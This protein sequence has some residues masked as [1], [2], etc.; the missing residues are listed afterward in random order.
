MYKNGH[1]VLNKTSHE[2]LQ[3][4][5]EWMKQFTNIILVAHNA[6]FD[7]RVIVRI[8]ESVGLCA[9]DFFVGFTDT[10]PLCRE[11]IPNR[12]SYKLIDLAK[13]I[14]SRHYDAHD[15]LSDAQTL[16]ELMLCVKVSSDMMLKHSF[17]TQFVTENISFADLTSR[18]LCSFQHL[19]DS[20]VLSKFTANK[21]ASS[22]LHFQHP[23]LAY[24]RDAVNGIKI[25]LS[26][27]YTTGKLR[28]T[29]NS[30]IISSLQQH[31]MNLKKICEHP[32]VCLDIVL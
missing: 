2:A 11:F 17:S 23:F 4:F 22:G 13:D 25:V 7:S 28:V 8:F 27:K 24:Q 14:C 32:I 29:S 31:F 21:I 20:N 1:Q 18:N 6:M 10:L 3:S 16:Q 26:D 30:R 12:K 15:A 5:I 9:S 19:V